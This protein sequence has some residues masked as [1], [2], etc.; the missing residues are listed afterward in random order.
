MRW[1]T[2]VR[3]YAI[4]A[5]IGPLVGVIIGAWLASRWQRRQWIADNKARE[6]REILDALNVYRWRLVNYQA[7]YGGVYA[8]VKPEDNL[9]LAEAQ[10][11]LDNSFSDRIFVR[12]TVVNSGAREAFRK[13]S[14]S[15]LSA[16]PPNLSESTQT[17]AKLHKKPVSVAET[18][19]RLAKGSRNHTPSPGSH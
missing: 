14:E 15:L 17:L 12:E 7:R 8:E 18:D 9:S 1:I 3:L 16:S 6:Y 11:A 4:W 19:L 2:E 5:A 13:F 10:I